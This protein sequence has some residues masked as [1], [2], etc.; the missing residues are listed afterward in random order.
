MSCPCFLLIPPKTPPIDICGTGWGLAAFFFTYMYMLCFFHAPI[1]LSSFFFFETLNAAPR[2]GHL[3]W[4]SHVKAQVHSIDVAVWEAK[5]KWVFLALKRILKIFRSWCWLVLVLVGAGYWLVL[6]LA[7]VG[8]GCWLVLVL[9][10]VGAGCWLVLVL[11]GVGAGWRRRCRRGDV[12]IVLEPGASGNKLE[13]D[14]VLGLGL[15]WDFEPAPVS[16]GFG[17][18]LV[19]QAQVCD[20]VSPLGLPIAWMWTWVWSQAQGPWTS[21]EGLLPLKPIYID[22]RP[23]V[24]F[25]HFKLAHTHSKPIPTSN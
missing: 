18:G 6:V 4:G 5:E 9:A 21:F 22:E 20:Q 8:A 2:T 7:G 24:L 23:L 15:R 25:T 19:H 13:E 12:V 17:L 1:F 14:E 11:A 16:F 10:S 3:G